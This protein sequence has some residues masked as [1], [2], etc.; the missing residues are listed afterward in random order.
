MWLGPRSGGAPAT[1]PA[2]G[3]QP[4]RA[5]SGRS[6]S[7]IRR[8]RSTISTSGTFLNTDCGKIRVSVDGVTSDHDLYLNEYGGTVANVKVRGG[9]RGRQPHGRDHRPVR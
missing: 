5:T 1:R 7:P 4:A 9:V 6:R 3:P 8:R 2:H